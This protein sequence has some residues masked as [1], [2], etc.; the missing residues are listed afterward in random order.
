[1]YIAIVLQFPLLVVISYNGV[2]ALRV[3]YKE[4]FLPCSNFLKA[5]LGQR[6]G[7]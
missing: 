5:F 7:I 4:V 6:N 1:M 3:C 2:V